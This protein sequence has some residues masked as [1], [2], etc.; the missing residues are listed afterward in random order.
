[1]GIVMPRS[2]GQIA[3]ESR[4]GDVVAWENINPLTHVTFELMAAAVAAEVERRL[5]E[6]EQQ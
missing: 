4:W 6:K 2:L 5:R 1:M 3:Y